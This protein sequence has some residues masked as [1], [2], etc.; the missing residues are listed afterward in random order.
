MI[1]ALLLK[2]HHNGKLMVL[3]QRH[4]REIL[5]IEVLYSSHLHR[6]KS[7]SIWIVILCVVIDICCQI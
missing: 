6:H 5:L 7:Y 3:S 2:L 4:L 1:H